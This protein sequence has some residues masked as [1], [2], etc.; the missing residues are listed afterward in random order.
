MKILILVSLLL[1]SMSHA[2]TKAKDAGKASKDICQIRA[3]YLQTLS[4]Q[5]SIN[6]NGKIHPVDMVFWKVDILE[7]SNPQNCPALGEN[8]IRVRDA[9]IGAQDGSPKITYR[10]GIDEPRAKTQV[11]LKVAYSKGEDSFTKL[12]FEEW[13]LKE[14]GRD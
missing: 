7:V 9:M 12:K 5:T 13:F 8:Q 3:K 10:V 11:D 6:R 2:T 4:E 14:V 1:S